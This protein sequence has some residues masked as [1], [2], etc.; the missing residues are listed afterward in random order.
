LREADIAPAQFPP[1]LTAAGAMRADVLPIGSD[2]ESARA[3]GFAAGFA[4]GARAAARAAETARRRAAHEREQAAR[5][6]GE[7]L[8]AAL[9]VLGAAAR[10]AQARDVPLL[11]E[12]EA[13]L[14]GAAISLAATVLGVELADEAT[15]SAAAL[16]RVRAA[17]QMADEVTVRLNPRDL[18]LLAD[19]GAVPAGVALVADPS[20]G[21]GEALAT[22][23]EGWLDGRIDEALRRA[24]A[25]LDGAS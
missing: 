8:E 23:D 3:A 1:L 24:R 15:A 2:P 6:A 17:G 19:L 18:A 9:A 11:A 21:R 12:A 7:Q 10:A 13:A 4:A 16:A 14:H 25:A 5:L 22:H 20:L